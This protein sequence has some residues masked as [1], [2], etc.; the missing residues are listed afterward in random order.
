M[1]YKE[2]STKYPIGKLLCRKVNKI[3]RGA[4]WYTEQDK[5]IYLAKDPEA[6]FTTNNG[7]IYPDTSIS[8]KRVKGWLRT[9]EGWFVAEDGWDG[10]TAL[11]EDDLAEIEA[12]GIAYEF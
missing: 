12:E 7:V 4:F 9:D 1:T 8:E 5:R 11:D 3:R 2:I 10:W 6:Q